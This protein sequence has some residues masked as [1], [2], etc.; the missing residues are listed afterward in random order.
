MSCP[1]GSISIHCALQLSGTIRGQTLDE[2]V[3]YEATGCGWVTTLS[4]LRVRYE[5]GIHIE[6]SIVVSSAG[7]EIGG[8]KRYRLGAS[9]YLYI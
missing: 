1:E 4:H 7:K 3:S 5:N 2:I 8:L 6:G 9:N